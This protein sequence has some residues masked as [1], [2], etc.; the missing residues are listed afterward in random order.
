ML[1]GS[2][3]NCYGASKYI[4]PWI[5]KKR[6]PKDEEEEIREKEA[7]RMAKEGKKMDISDSESDSSSDEEDIEP[8]RL[9]LD[10]LKEE[11]KKNRKRGI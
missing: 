10:Q 1:T 7:K 4:P 11:L 9:T 6:I 3:Q 8:S 2:S 5:D